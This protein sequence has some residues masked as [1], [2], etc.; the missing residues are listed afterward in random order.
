MA[1]LRTAADKAGCEAVLAL[2]D[3]K[4]T[5]SAFPAGEGYEY[6]GTGTDDY[7]EDDDEYSGGESGANASTR[8]RS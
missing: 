6:R 4:T 3:I 1:L 8:S 5:H 2:A 7:D